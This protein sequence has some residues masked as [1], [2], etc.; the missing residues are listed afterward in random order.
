MRRVR[1]GILLAVMAVVTGCGPFTGRPKEVEPQPTGYEE[2]ETQAALDEP[3][4]M[5][6]RTEPAT[7]PRRAYE[8]FRTAIRERDFETCWRLLSRDTH[9]AYERSAA[10]LKM[11]VLNSDTPPPQ[12]L[13][14]LHVLGL[15]RKEVDKLTGKMAMRGSFQRAAERDPV[16][17]E[18]ITRTDFDHES[19]YQD[20]ATVHFI[21][22]DTRQVEQM[23]LVRE[24][25]VW[26]IEAATPVKTLPQ[27]GR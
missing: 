25:G 9:D 22:R 17:F 14:L 21:S 6:V 3:A 12:D 24:G 11:R 23:R 10:D 5:T 18:T 16:G 19:I 4:R 15:T 7:S 1:M 20:R 27:S 13:E 2:L 8:I 26:R